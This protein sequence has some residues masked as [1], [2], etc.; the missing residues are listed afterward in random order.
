MVDGIMP[1]QYIYNKQVHFFN[2]SLIGKSLQ[3]ITYSQP[4]INPQFYNFRPKFQT[5]ENIDF[6]GA[7]SHGHHTIYSVSCHPDKDK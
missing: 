7:E 4:I 6:I 2:Y 1:K 5:L 3:S